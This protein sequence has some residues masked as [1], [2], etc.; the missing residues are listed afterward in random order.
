MPNNEGYVE[1]EPSPDAHI[2]QDAPENHNQQYDMPQQEYTEAVA[3]HQRNEEQEMQ[4]QYLQP[5]DG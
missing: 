5:D 2:I 4:N 1:V 3:D